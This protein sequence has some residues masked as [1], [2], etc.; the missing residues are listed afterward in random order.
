[1]LNNPKGYMTDNLPV[2]IQMP[3]HFAPDSSHEIDPSLMFFPNTIDMFTS[4]PD[5][6]DPRNMMPHFQQD[7][8]KSL[9][10][11]QADLQ[12]IFAS[13]L[14]QRNP[15]LGFKSEQEAL[16]GLK[17]NEEGG[18]GSDSDGKSD[19]SNK[20]GKYR[21]Y[22][23]DEK[24]HIINFM[25]KHG[26][27]KTLEIF[28]GGEHK[29]TKRKL[30]SWL[31]NQ[32]KVKGVKGRKSTDPVRDDVL[33]KWCINFQTEHGRP[34]SRK[35][36]TTKA[37]E[38]SGDPSFQASK[39]WLDKFSRKF[40]IEFTPL[41]IIPPRGRK[42]VKTG[43]NE[44]GSAT[45]TLESVLAG[46]G[47][48]LSPIRNHKMKKLG[49]EAE[50]HPSTAIS[51]ESL[52]DPESIHKSGSLFSL[53][54]KHKQMK[55]RAQQPDQQPQNNFSQLA[56]SSN[57]GMVGGLDPSFYQSFHGH[58]MDAA[59]PQGYPYPIL[60]PMNFA[61]SMQY[62]FNEQNPVTSRKPYPLNYPMNLP[63]NL[64]FDGFQRLQ[65]MIKKDDMHLDKNN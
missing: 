42:K 23:D 6:M 60:Y 57:E 1:M 21:T 27:Q 12:S 17:A 61:N 47:G 38:L 54:A 20:R 2:D 32:N 35:E 45:S 63:L 10:N 19:S 53:N 49:L 50:K 31:E 43:E 36:T 26:I 59:K 39:G 13:Q 44:A 41:K 5:E 15:M 62:N 34:P 46:V 51:E 56:P 58:G 29:I 11:P 8:K 65:Q 30:K 33:Y 14:N 25:M 37:L 55:A 22:T 18:D 48:S 40:N 7:L 3:S 16:E 64:G 24:T 9:Q 52:H 28:S 4:I